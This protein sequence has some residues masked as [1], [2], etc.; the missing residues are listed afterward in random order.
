MVDQEA[1]ERVARV[2]NMNR[3][4]GRAL[5]VSAQHFARLCRRYGIETPYARHRRRLAGASTHGGEMVENPDAT[6]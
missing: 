5:G 6:C 3:D 1:V 4:A 2:Y